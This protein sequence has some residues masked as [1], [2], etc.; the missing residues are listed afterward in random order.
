[1]STQINQQFSAPP[2]MVRMA[3]GTY[4][5]AA[6]QDKNRALSEKKLLI[7]IQYYEGDQEESEQLGALIADLERIRNRDADI[8]IYRRH[9][10]PEF[11][12]SVRSKLEEKFDKVFFETCR[13]KDAK[14]YPFAANQMWHDLVTLVA[15]YN[16]WRTN[17]Y[18]FLPLEADCVPVR[19]GWIRELIAE[20][21]HAK[22]EGFAATGFIHNDPTP[23]MNGVAVYDINIWGIVG[24]G[25]LNGGNAQVAYDIYHGRNLLPVSMNTPLIMF[26]Y[27]RP[28][29]SADDLFRPWR[30]G[31]EPALFHGVKDASAREAVRAKWITFSKEKD[32][33]RKTVFTFCAQQDKMKEKLWL[34]GWRSR[35]WNPV[36]LSPRDAVRNPRY[37][38]VSK[39]VSSLPIAANIEEIHN[40]ILRWLALDSMGAGL[41][42]DM[43]VLPARFTPSELPENSTILGADSHTIIAAYFDRKTL[44]EYLDRLANY[45]VAPHDLLDG[46]PHVTDLGILRNSEVKY[47]EFPAVR[48]Y[49][50]TGWSESPMVEFKQARLIQCGAR[51][52]P[53][54]LMGVFLQTS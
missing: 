7:V 54:Q 26:Q 35:G 30:D 19:P 27:R 16:P 44:G 12:R 14:G 1:M 45:Q 2:P 37:A 8:L 42:V 15:Q 34:D 18:A 21:K 5:P 24:G 40:R 46:V 20:F 41:M 39:R 53:T 9:D 29:I 10:A 17:Y 47:A 36:V 25:I 52:T 38:A 22:A 50:E 28:T 32:I 48:S 33:S 11:S 23:H 31:V 43:D 13:R 4:L 49:Q 3:N 6:Q 51:G